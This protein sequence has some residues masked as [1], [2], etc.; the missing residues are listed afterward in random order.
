M[1][2]ERKSELRRRQRRRKKMLKLRNKL[3]AATSNNEKNR[4]VAK[5][6]RIN[7]FAFSQKESIS[8]EVKD[9]SHVPKQRV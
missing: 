3:R 8:T 5:M 4:I 7:P 6:M 9:S 1:A 2:I